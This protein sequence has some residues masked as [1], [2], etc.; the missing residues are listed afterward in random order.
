MTILAPA[1]AS[2]MSRL[3]PLTIDHAG[4]IYIRLA[5]G[6]DPIVTNDQM[7]F[8]IGR[9]YLM[10]E[11]D[12]ALIISTGVLLK[13]ALDAAD[14]LRVRGLEAAV[15]HVPTVKPLDSGAIVKHASRVPVI[16]AAEEHSVIGG[17]GSAV[18]EVL[19]EAN[20]SSPKSFRRIGIPDVFPDQYGSQDSL[21]AYYDITAHKICLTVEDLH[22]KLRTQEDLTKTWAT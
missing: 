17:L 7:Q 21:M 6:G 4:P 18:A 12:D 13:R 8:E 10:R 9:T 2:E 11:G 5:K 16:V 20:F 14:I 22:G 1:D 3:M 19:A 15:L